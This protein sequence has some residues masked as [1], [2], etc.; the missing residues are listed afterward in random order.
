M[1]ARVNGA[2]VGCCGNCG[3]ELVIKCAG[4][5]TEPDI[6]FR[7]RSH[8]VKRSR[9]Q[10]KRK[11]VRAKDVRPGYCTWQYGCDQKASTRTYHGRPVKKCEKHLAVL[12][13]YEANRRAKEV[14]AA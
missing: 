4:G 3:H 6:T 9:L 11:R 13:K 2:G 10:R 12:R 8:I 1:T 14:I 5:C 7:E